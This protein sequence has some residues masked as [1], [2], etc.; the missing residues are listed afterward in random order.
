MFNRELF[1]LRIRQL[2]QAKNLTMKSL[3]IELSLS[4]SG[5]ISNLENS[6]KPPS[7]EMLFILADFFDVSIDYLVGRSN[8]PLRR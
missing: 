8:D 6:K 2:R 4:G 1:G 3:A 7:I 5:T